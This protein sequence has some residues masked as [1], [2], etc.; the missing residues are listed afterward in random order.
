M[1]SCSQ[2]GLLRL[3]AGLVSAFLLHSARAQ[4]GVIREYAALAPKPDAVPL[5]P[6]L[7][8]PLTDTSIAGGADRAFY[9]TGS[10]VA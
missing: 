7:D 2:P 6:L 9:L 10:S 3:I 4:H 8:T 5:A 1:K